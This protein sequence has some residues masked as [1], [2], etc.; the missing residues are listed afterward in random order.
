MTDSG[1]TL[2]AATPEEVKSHYES[3][4]P[5]KEQTPEFDLS[6]MGI[7]PL[8]QIGFDDWDAFGVKAANVAVL[9]RWGFQ[10]ERFPDGFAIPFYFYDEFMKANGF[11]DDVTAMLADPDFQTDFE[12]QDDMLDDLRDDIEGRGDAAVDHRR[13]DHHA[14]HVPGGAIAALPVE[15]EQRGPAG[16]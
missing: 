5:A 1:W 6:V 4:R 11:Y 10:R 14:R 12:T 2:R 7:K 8:S 16:L 15:H 9:G 3:F 13:P